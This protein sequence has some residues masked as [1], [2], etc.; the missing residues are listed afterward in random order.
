MPTTEHTLHMCQLP[1]FRIPTPSPANHHHHPIGISSK[2]PASDPTNTCCR[3]RFETGYTRGLFQVRGLN[4]TAGWV[5]GAWC[6]CARFLNYCL[7]IDYVSPRCELFLHN[8]RPLTI[9]LEM[10]NDQHGKVNTITM[11]RKEHFWQKHV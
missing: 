4:S 1:S 9:E 2:R 10:I 11:V 7:I 6:L 3:Q 8:Y 5:P